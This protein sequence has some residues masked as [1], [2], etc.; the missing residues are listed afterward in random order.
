MLVRKFLPSDA[1]ALSQIF[2]QNLRQVNIRDYPSEAIEALV[3]LYTPEQIIERAGKWITLVCTD[4]QD[5][6]GTASLDN[7]RVREVFVAVSQHRTGDWQ[8]TNACHRDDGQ[9]AASRKLYLLA[10][11][12][13]E[14]FYKKLG[15]VVIKRFD[16]DLNGIPLRVIR[17]EKDI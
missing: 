1:E 8:A 2:I 16:N 7:D 9:R 13:A 5:V 17:M 10:G 3:R 12:S 15:Y 11:I 14:D 4:G 6:V